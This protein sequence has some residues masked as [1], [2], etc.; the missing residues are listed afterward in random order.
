LQVV[1]SR[2]AAGK[3]AAEKATKSKDQ[4]FRLPRGRTGSSR[5]E[6]CG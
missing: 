1:K 6:F 3:Q 4:N 5:P 2:L